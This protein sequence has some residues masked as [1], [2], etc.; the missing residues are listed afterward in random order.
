MVKKAY[1]TIG[2]EIVDL[3]IRWWK[4][5]V[6]SSISEKFD[7]TLEDLLLPSILI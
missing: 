3:L 6:P 4:T 5:L 1:D 2:T 7:I